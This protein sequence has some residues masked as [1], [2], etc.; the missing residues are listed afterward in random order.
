MPLI[1]TTC[2]A[3]YIII[4]LADLHYCGTG[5]YIAG[6]ATMYYTSVSNMPVCEYVTVANI[7]LH[8]LFVPY[9][10][11]HDYGNCLVFHN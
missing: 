7:I 11:M 6:S 9:P 3:V 4:N 1:R 5:G 10:M 2:F 8:I